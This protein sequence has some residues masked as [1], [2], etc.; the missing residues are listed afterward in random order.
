MPHE[1]VDLLIAEVSLVDDPANE[2]PFL[3]I[4]NRTGD[5]TV[6]DNQLIELALGTDLE[7]EEAIDKKIDGLPADSQDALKGALRILQA[8]RE[9]ITSDVLKS[10]AP[11][12]GVEFQAEKTEDGGDP[13]KGK[14][15]GV[16]DTSK[17]MPE[18][19][20]ILQALQKSNSTLEERLQKSDAKVAELD[21]ARRKDDMIL[22]VKDLHLAKAEPDKLADA[23]LSLQDSSPEAYDQLSEILTATSA[24]V[25]ES[26]LLKAI[27][28]DAAGDATETAYEKVAKAAKKM[29]E[30]S[31]GEISFASAQDKVLKQ[32]RDLARQYSEEIR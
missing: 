13:P 7:N 18:V 4:K 3:L 10:L 11:E 21:R 31:N 9:N 20:A 15:D 25:V 28:S 19:A 2:R 26:D 12:M 1:I 5:T 23:L 14:D 32:D 6:A 8:H 17:L 16:G 29:V 22:K 27:G 30:N 24:V